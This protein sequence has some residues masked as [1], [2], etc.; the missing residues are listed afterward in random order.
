MQNAAD[1]GGYLKGQLE[2]LQS[3]FEV[4]GDVR[5]RGLMIGVELVE[6]RHT[7]TRAA[8]LRGQVLQR[9]FEK[10]LIILGAGANTV[11]WAPPLVIDRPTVDL[12][13]EIFADVL[14]ETAG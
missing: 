12:A 3:E 13:V 1:V 5:G 11:R 4:M 14:R 9:C 7:K 2:E 10:G 6:D 8:E